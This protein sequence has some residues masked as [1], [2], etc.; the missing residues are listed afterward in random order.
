M[1]VYWIW[2]AQLPE[3][4]LRQKHQILERF[5]DAEELYFAEK[6]KLRDLPETAV[7]ALE[8]KD[9]TEAD[10]ILQVCAR[11]EIEV[12]IFTD[13][14][15]PHRLR[16]ISDPPLVLYYRGQLP[17]WERQPLIAAVGTR[18]AT[19]YG[20]TAAKK[21]S[22]QMAS[23]GGMVVSGCASGV[24]SAAMNG[25]LEAGGV[26]VGV[27]GCGIDV[28]YP[29][30]NRKLYADIVKEGC[31]ISEYEPGSKPEPWH[32]PQRN[33]IMSGISNGV[34]VIEAP[35]KSGALITARCALEQGRDVFVV[36]GNIDAPSCAGSNALLQD[37]AM[38]VLSGWDVVKEYEAQ[39]P[40][41]VANRPV[42]VQAE[43]PENTVLVAQKTIDFPQPA[44]KK[45]IDKVSITSYSG[46]ENPLNQI[47]DEEKRL[48][49]CLTY[50]PQPV[51]DVIA[52]V[53]GTSG[54]I[55]SMLTKL[56]LQG[57][58]QNHPGRLV[59]LKKR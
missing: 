36:P 11:K 44:D 55:L 20:I 52:A 39:Y 21:L 54:R 24:D 42:P 8:H 59:S 53:G 46:I 19:P 15:Y 58:V 48:L 3:L 16:N 37:G 56:S 22:R 43:R 10:K 35:E 5:S 33:R 25:A 29:R 30:T 57:M 47:S 41:S 7:K 28:I 32:F 9:L 34:L 51:D 50:D 12:L 31:L 45:D 1:L 27:L 38:A 18:K 26:T 40:E 4:S 13:E 14:K 2:L 49:A 17:D 6:E 23:C